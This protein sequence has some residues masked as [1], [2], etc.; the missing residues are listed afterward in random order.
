[1]AKLKSELSTGKTRRNLKRF[2]GLLVVGFM[3]AGC[4]SVSTLTTS[5]QDAC[6]QYA[7]AL[8]Q[9]N[10]DAHNHNSQVFSNLELDTKKA[11]E[12]ASNFLKDQLQTMQSDLNAISSSLGNRSQFNAAVT[13][14][15]KDL[16]SIS[17]HCDSKA[18][19]IGQ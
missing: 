5:E 19:I 3:M 1:M 14:F 18:F 12:N 11:S 13:R 17:D 4:A 15:E 9:F 6:H 10:K 8:A 16:K 2:V 7:N